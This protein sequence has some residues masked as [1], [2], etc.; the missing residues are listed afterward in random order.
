MNLST[1]LTPR[2]SAEGRGLLSAITAGKRLGASPHF[3]LPTLL[4]RRIRRLGLTTAILCFTITRLVAAD[5]SVEVFTEDSVVTEESTVTSAENG[6][7]NLLPQRRLKLSASILNGYDDNVSTSTGGGGSA[8][9]QANLTV[10]KD[11][12]TARTQLSIVMRTG[13]VYYFDR[14]DSRG[15][16]VTGSV[17]ASLRHSVSQRLTLAA[18]IDAAYLTEPQFQTDLEPARR[19]NYFSTSDTFTANYKWSPRLS[20]DSSYQLRGL[21]DKSFSF[22]D[23]VQHT[24]GESLRFLWSPRTTLVADYRFGLVDYDS[25]SRDSS[26]HTA[27]AGLD[28]QINSRLQATVRGGATFRKYQDAQNGE[29]TDPNASASLRYTIGP[30]TSVNWT[31]G[32]SIEEPNSAVALARTTFRTS[33]QLGYQFTRRL[34]GQLALNYNH[35]ENAGLLIPGFPEFGQREFTDDASALVLGVK[36]AVARRVALNFEF[37]HTE[38]D[39][40]GLTGGGYSRNRYTVGLTFNY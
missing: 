30:S 19:G 26:T 31:V 23:R 25:S 35:N 5:P 38:F 10:S 40:P 17:R 13:V 7:L 11:L 8:T 12:A 34:S 4:V 27:L 14:A 20:I 18:S 39:S 32:Y 9:T 16:D 36:Y 28:Y 2:P 22:G 21:I 3:H 37:T 6:V 29:R 24:F 33:L 15:T 1:R